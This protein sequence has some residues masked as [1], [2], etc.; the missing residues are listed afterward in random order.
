M[1]VP[2]HANQFAIN[3]LQWVTA[4]RGT[5]TTQ[6]PDGSDDFANPDFLPVYDSILGRV[7][8]AGFPAVMLKV[9][10][11]QTVPSYKAM[12]AQHGLRLAPG[13]IGVP[14]PEDEITI[15]K[16]GSL[17]WF[18][19]FDQVR[20]RAEE[21][22]LCGLD[23]VFI[24]ATIATRGHP[25]V[26]EAAAIGFAY[27]PG[28]LDRVIDTLST[29]VDVLAREGV[30]AGLHN[31][32]G[33][34]IETEAEIDAVLTAIPTLWCGFDI[35]HLVWA[36]IDPMA[37]IARYHDRVIDLHIK[38]IDLTVAAACRTHHTSYQSASASGLFLEPGLGGIDLVGILAQLP[39]GFDKTIIV[40]VD[41]PSMDPDAS[42]R[43]SWRWI[44]DHYGPAATHA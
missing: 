35:G 14:L 22:L 42:A 10:P 43:T 44:L 1:P 13:Y 24:A 32:V 3:P 31:H 16:P 30:R 6:S 18:H 28:R 38:D 37:M 17:A 26:D 20:R 12:V 33:T 15:I 34:W 36:G 39:T 19:W 40:E 5:G 8:D 9:P 2:L 41:R 11:T 23:R 29:A 25:R 21:S 7:A 27:D 4:A